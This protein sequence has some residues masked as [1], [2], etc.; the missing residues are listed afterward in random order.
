MGTGM[1]IPTSMMFDYL[2]KQ[3]YYKDAYVPADKYYTE[4]MLYTDEDKANLYSKAEPS[5]AVIATDLQ[6]NLAKVDDNLRNNLTKLRDSANRSIGSISYDTQ[7]NLLSNFVNMRL[8]QK[9]V[10]GS[11]LGQGYKDDMVNDFQASLDRAYESY[12]KNFK[13]NR[14]SIMDTLDNSINTA[15]N[16]AEQIK[17][18]FRQNAASLNERITQSIEEEI[19]AM[20]EYNQNALQFNSKLDEHNAYV[21]DFIY[22]EAKNYSTYYAAIPEYIDWL[23]EQ[24]QKGELPIDLME[25]DSWSKYLREDGTYMGADEISH[26]MYT[27]IEYDE[28]GN[29][30]EDST[31]T[32]LGI[33][34]VNQVMNEMSSRGYA[35]FSFDKY[36]SDTDEELYSWLT[37]NNKYDNTLNNYQHANKLLGIGDEEWDN[38]KEKQ[39]DLKYTVKEAG[40]SKLNFDNNGNSNVYY[41]N[42]FGTIKV[43]PPTGTTETII[44]FDDL[45]MDG[46]ARDVD[47]DNFTMTYED[48]EGITRKYKFE[49][50]DEE[51]GENFRIASDNKIYK[52]IDKAVGG[53]KAGGI[54]SYGGTDV[55]IAIETDGGLV[56]RKLQGQGAQ[57]DDSLYNIFVR[58]MTNKK[59]W[60]KNLTY[61]ELVDKY[62]GSK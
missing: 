10:E 5:R 23:F 30:I 42:D 11:N 17:E 33:E 4:D 47:G 55:Y 39:D 24:S 6:L 9:S 61:D 16:N 38:T 12:L 51:D 32:P 31:L 37:E 48:D 28:N 45:V 41:G 57:S 3:D 49:V 20:D 13:H 29:I 60:G 19:A 54:Y 26:L 14:E 35:G 2:Q 34:I 44:A 18:S 27:P 62:G 40:S 22:N 46:N 53:I 21:D 1:N 43:Y 52:N 25:L 58:T 59:E 36:L 56:L 50:A 15:I 7:N 8:Q